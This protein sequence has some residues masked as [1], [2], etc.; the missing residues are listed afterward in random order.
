MTSSWVLIGYLEISH[1]SQ[2][3]KVLLFWKNPFVRHWMYTRKIKVRVQV[4]PWLLS[5][6]TEVEGTIWHLCDFFLKR[7]NYSEE[8]LGF[9]QLTSPVTG[10]QS[11]KKWWGPRKNSLPIVRMG[12]KCGEVW[13]TREL[14]SGFILWVALKSGSSA[15]IANIQKWCLHWI[16]PA[17]QWHLNM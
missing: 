8:L 15:V 17:L 12:P 16:M 5:A 3:I 11:Q 4:Q 2:P 10:S 7:R 6:L 1:P 9:P 14:S 13:K